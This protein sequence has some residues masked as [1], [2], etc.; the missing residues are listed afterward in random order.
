M[1]QTVEYK[2]GLLKLQGDMLHADTRRGFIR[3][4]GTYDGLKSFSWKER[5]SSNTE[6]ELIIFPDEAYFTRLP[7]CT[8][9]KAYLLELNQTNQ[10][11]FFWLQEPESL[12]KADDIEKVV[13]TFFNG[14]NNPIVQPD[15]AKSDEKTPTVASLPTT[16]EDGDKKQDSDMKD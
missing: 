11:F 5:T 12:N 3:L 1:Q 6:L 9:G 7:K 13:N 2:A 16:A 8:D 14:H 15:S 10:R 4:T